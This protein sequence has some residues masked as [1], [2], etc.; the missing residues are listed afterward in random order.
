MRSANLSTLV[1]VLIATTAVSACAQDHKTRNVI[2][3]MTDGFR[4]EEAFRGADP[5]LMDKKHGHVG[6]LKR[7][8]A[9]YWR[10]TAADRRQAL[11]PFLWTV[12]KRDGQIYGNRD[13]ASDAFVTNGLNFSYPGYSEAFCGFADPRINS[14]DK[15]PN[16]NVNVLEWL[17]Q[18]S[19]F[20]GKIAA[21]GAWEVFPYIFNAGRSGLLVNSGPP[22]T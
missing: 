16:P 9:E 2:F 4:W 12:V 20:A 8:Q 15:K 21:F 3:V 22:V 7:L 10:D 19:E 6:D 13:L 14:N 5:A 11:L 17:N 18:K 1:C